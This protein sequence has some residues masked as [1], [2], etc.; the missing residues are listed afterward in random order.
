MLQK[1]WPDLDECAAH[2]AR[3]DATLIGLPIC[4]SLNQLV[5]HAATLFVLVLPFTEVQV[6]AQHV[7]STPRPTT[8]KG[9]DL[10]GRLHR[11]GNRS[12]TKA[13]AVLFLAAKCPISESYLSSLSR[14][15]G[16]YR[17][18]GVEFY[19][20][21]SNSSVTLAE[22]KEYER[23][24]RIAFPILFD[25]SG[26]LWRALSPSHMPQAFV[27][28]QQGNVLYS[29]AI[30]NKYERSG[31]PREKVT[32]EYLE[33]AIKSV[34]AG[35]EIT[36][37]ET[38]PVGRMLDAP[39][40]KSKV[41]T[42][43]FTRD[44]APIIL[45]NCSSCH[46]PGQA[47]PFPLLTYDD[48][49]R[50]A[51]Q[52]AEVTRSKYMPPWKPQAG[53]G[54][55]QDAR[56]L[57]QHEIALL[58]RWSMTG[59]QKGDPADMPSP[60]KFAQGWQLG[61]PDK[62]LKMRDLF[63]VP[64]SGPDIRQYFVI[65]TRMRDSRLINAVDFHPG[66]ARVIHH[67]SFYLDTTGTAR[68]LDEK[69]P[70]PGYQGFGGPGFRASG[71]LRSWLPGMTP[72]RLPKGMGRLIPRGSDLVLEI[73]YTCTGKPEHD[74]SM[75]GL[76]HAPRS[77][78]QLVK[79]LLIGNMLIKILPGVQRHHE[80]ATYELPVETIL[81]DVAP[82]MHV[83]GREMKAT[84]TLPN[85]EVE[86]LVWI[87]DW[88]FNWQGQYSYVRPVRLP[89]GTR[90]DVDAWYDNSAENPL[91]PNSPPRTVYWGEDATDEMLMCHFQC[92]CSS[93][94]ELKT[95]TEDYQNYQSDQEDA[96]KSHRRR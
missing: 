92:T 50:H 38:E 12:D 95:L 45:A 64:A 47:A 35:I 83:L 13:V 2:G 28:N 82:H 72:K 40:D 91:N 87:K 16:R 27:L 73:H 53:F 39:P 11:F 74:R 23:R 79:E 19:G 36:T 15:S 71:S 25:S 6:R 94:D 8:L 21:I 18:R 3:K 22:A 76:Y 84:A 59:K 65:P 81:L 89:K 68:R 4:Q 55:F 70:K 69:D 20:V 17:Q 37:R 85:G 31:I 62:I 48:V 44:I 30:D 67:A 54:R 43:T 93:Y 66:C 88:D 56:G 14:L 75:I 90:I 96:W 1:S 51:R 57:T 29:G 60:P 80:R 78:R 9:I 42:I 24:F 49:R 5:V 10:T 58:K 77:S 32:E 61:P 7:G 26:E 46:R 86:P 41:G 33:D 63:H 34:I 52:I